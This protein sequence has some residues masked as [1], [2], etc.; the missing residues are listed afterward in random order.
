MRQLVGAI[1]YAHNKGIVHR[2][3]KP[4][5][6]LLDYIEENTEDKHEFGEEYNNNVIRDSDN[7]K[8]IVKLIDWGLSTFYEDKNG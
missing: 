3:I 5:N 4:E 8:F 7:K 1:K 2:D 6:I